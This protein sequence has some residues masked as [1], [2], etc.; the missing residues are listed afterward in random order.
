LYKTGC[1]ELKTNQRDQ[2]IY[3]K[4]E[5]HAGTH[6]FVI[7]YANTLVTEGGHWEE[8]AWHSLVQMDRWMSGWKEGEWQHITQK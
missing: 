5:T 7:T 6:E 1:S 8:T 3:F 2:H 4:L